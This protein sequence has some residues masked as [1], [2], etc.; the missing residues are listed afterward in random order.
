MNI[1][2]FD[3]GGHSGVALRLD[4]ELSTCITMN[5]KDTW[6]FIQPGLD[7]IVYERFASSIATSH[8]ALYTIELC[9]G[10]QALA[11]RLGI[12]VVRHEPQNRIAFV[13]K[14]REIITE[15]RGDDVKGDGFVHEADALAHLLAFEYLESRGKRARTRNWGRGLT[16]ITNA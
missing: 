6:D 5:Y 1:L 10:I 4:G 2:A 14:A 16:A 11:E 8:D 13:T 9:G 12:E 7:V 15:M 3:P